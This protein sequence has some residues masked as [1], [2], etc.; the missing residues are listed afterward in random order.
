HFAASAYV[1]VS[2]TDPRGYYANNLTNGL[3]LLGAML[4]AGVR[5]L[6]FSSSC[7]VFGHQ[8][9]PLLDEEHPK[10]PANPYGD[11]KLAFEPALHWF[12]GA[13]GLRS[14]A[15]R[16]FNA[17]GADPEGEIGERHDPETHLVPNVLAA[18]SGALPVLEI[19]GADH[20]TPDGT[21]IRD[22]VHVTDLA[23]AHL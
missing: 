11:T 10:A 17:A 5:R 4:D 3:G 19:F 13:Y 12:D 6:V 7:A 1:G 16:F 22:Y 20:P 14:V 9:T 23:A 18:A 21:A 15:L 8:R 2:M